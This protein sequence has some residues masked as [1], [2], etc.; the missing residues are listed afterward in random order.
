[1]L[2][3][4]G[5]IAMWTGFVSIVV[6]SIWFYITAFQES[7]LTG[8]AVLFLPI[9]PIIFLILCWDRAKRP[10]LLSL[11]GIGVALLGVFVFT[12]PTPWH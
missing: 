10:F 9:V 1:M 4:I 8:L 7:L 11:L 12:A 6:G 3:T 2:T 5:V